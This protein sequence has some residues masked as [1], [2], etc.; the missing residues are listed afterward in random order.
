MCF[1]YLLV[2]KFANFMA[3][4]MRVK[5]CCISLLL[6]TGRIRDAMYNALAIASFAS[7]AL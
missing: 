7:I 3:L 2:A 6:Y 4:F 5:L 1:I